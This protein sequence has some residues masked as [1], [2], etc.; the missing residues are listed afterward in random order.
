[1]R[2]RVIEVP[3]VA[4]RDFHDVAAIVA[5]AREKFELVHHALVGEQLRAFLRDMRLRALA[6][7]HLPCKRRAVPALD[8]VVEIGRRKEDAAVAVQH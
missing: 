8:E 3:G 4:K 1:M 7:R 2:G 5:H 6:E